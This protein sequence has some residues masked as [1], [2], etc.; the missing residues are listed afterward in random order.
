MKHYVLVFILLLFSGCI[1]IPIS[2]EQSAINPYTGN[3]VLVFKSNKTGLLDTLYLYKV[4]RLYHDGTPRFKNYQIM[5]VQAFIPHYY[6]FEKPLNRNGIFYYDG[7][8]EISLSI[9]LNKSVTFFARLNAPDFF[10]GMAIQSLEVS[11]KNYNDVVIVESNGSVASQ[12]YWSKSQGYI[13][14]EMA[15]GEKF[16]LVNKFLDTVKCEALRV[17]DKIP[18]SD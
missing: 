12:I 18:F 10:N 2:T 13:A 4:Q 11:D 14:V 9:S 3:E 17:R 15:S 8:E 1:R 16:E 6:G 7:K 5:T